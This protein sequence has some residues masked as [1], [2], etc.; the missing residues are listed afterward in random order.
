MA[1]IVG[2][3]SG[4]GVGVD[5]QASKMSTSAIENKNLKFIYRSVGAQRA[6]P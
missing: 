5:S 4:L 1:A 2:E 6:G 3:T